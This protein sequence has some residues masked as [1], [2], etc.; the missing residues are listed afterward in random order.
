MRQHLMFSAALTL[1]SS[2]AL[3][4]SNKPEAAG[5]ATPTVNTGTASESDSSVNDHMVA[6]SALV[7]GANSFTQGEA[8]SRLER[9]GLSGVSD[10]KK[11]D[12]GIWRGKATRGGKDVSVGL[13]FKGNIAAE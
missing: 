12:M 3:A 6:S 9:A 2:M 8:R 7:E 1:L 5:A 13:D 4:Q 11:D 10:L